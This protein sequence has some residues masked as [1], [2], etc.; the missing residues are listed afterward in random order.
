MKNL[1]ARD[2]TTRDLFLEKELTKK[3]VKFL[4]TNSQLSLLVRWAV[5]KQL[6]KV[7]PLVSPVK[8]KNRCV[9]T[10]RGKSV[11]RPFRLS[12][13]LFRDYARSGQMLGVFKKSW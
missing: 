13:I 7:S 5:G 10:F 12:R 1:L 11:L 9:G 6:V 2:K 8:M 3:A 4:R